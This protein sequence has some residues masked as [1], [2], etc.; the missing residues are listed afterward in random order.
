V[1]PEASVR[2]SRLTEPRLR[3]AL[4]GALLA[5]AV[6]A[7]VALAP[8]PL[9]FV[10]SFGSDLERPFELFAF[11]GSLALALIALLEARARGLRDAGAW[12]PVALGLAVGFHVLGLVVELAEKRF[13][14]SCYEEAARS[15]AAGG[16]PYANRE[17]WYHYP[18]ALAEAL[19]AGHAALMAGFGLPAVVAWDRVFYVH[20]A[21][22]VPLAL[23]AFALLARVARDVGVGR[24][25]AALLAAALVLVNA[26][27]LRTVAWSQ[28][29]LWVL[30]CVLLAVV[31]R[32]RAP[33]WA[34]VAAAAGGHLKLYPVA[35]LGP[36]LLTRQWRACLGAAL[37]G[38]GLLVVQIAAFGA[39]PWSAYLAFLPEF[40]RGGFF[41]DN[42]LHAVVYNLWNAAVSLGG[43][44]ASA[45]RVLAVYL[46]AAAAAAALLGTRVLRRERAAARA[47]PSESGGGAGQGVR[48]ALR[49]HGHAADAV[50]LGLIAAPIVWEHHYVLACPVV[51]WA[52]GA[53][54]PERRVLL[55]AAALAMLAVPS[56]DVF[57]W[58]WHRLAGLAA[59]LALTRPRS[60]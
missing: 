25:A 56:F 30:D 24:S 34:G 59:L 46:V 2:G 28:V 13:D 21:L 33:L 50:A 26:P 41:R 60:A 48:E 16:H 32:G 31:L 58:S 5:G 40:R 51:A 38:L 9:P 3:L 35:L 47:L 18:P 20:Q 29:N 45:G 53:C 15:L 17:F 44:A 1:A 6:L 4:H 14:W 52:A 42:G 19:A 7:P 43:P 11:T 37:G 36:W 12:L 8:L 27:L 39:G 55:G 54:A 49:H 10:R 57:P 22:Q 23:G